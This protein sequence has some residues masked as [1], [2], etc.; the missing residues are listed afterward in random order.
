MPNRLK[1]EPG[2]KYGRL[3]VVKEASPKI[4]KDRYKF[5]MFECMCDCGKSKIAGL[6]ALMCGKVQ[7]CGCLNREKI[8][9]LGKGNKKHGVSSGKV[10]EGIWRSYCSWKAM[11]RRC[12]GGKQEARKRYKDRGIKVCER[13]RE[14]ANFLEDMGERPLNLTLERINNDGNYEPFNCK[15][16]TRKEQANNR[17]FNNQHTIRK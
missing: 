9:K 2:A 7:S 15:W 17:A 8:I 10:A 12:S 11:N 1:L 13:W 14:F 16:A 3:V 5:R 6:S 4:Y